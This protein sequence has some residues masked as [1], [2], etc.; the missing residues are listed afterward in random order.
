MSALKDVTL[1]LRP[2]VLGLI[3][4]IER[5]E[6]I[7]EVRQLTGELRFWLDGDVL[8]VVN[9]LKLRNRHSVTNAEQRHVVYKSQGD[10]PKMIITEMDVGQSDSRSCSDF[11]CADS[12]GCCDGGVGGYCDGGLGGCS[13]EIIHLP[14]AAP[15]GAAPNGAAP[16]GVL[17]GGSSASVNNPETMHLTDASQ[18]P[19]VENL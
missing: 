13:E 3:S 19:T 5:S 9:S 6:S 14:T 15:N 17:T 4:D 10:T 1:N 8:S 16:K 18:V 12:N 2:V 11:G 7:S